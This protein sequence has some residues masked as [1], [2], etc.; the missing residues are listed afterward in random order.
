MILGVLIQ[1]TGEFV[2]PWGYFHIVSKIFKLMVSRS[3]YL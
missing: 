2:I 3:Y 1:I